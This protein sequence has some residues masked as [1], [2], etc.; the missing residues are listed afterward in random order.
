MNWGTYLF[1]VIRQRSGGPSDLLSGDDG[2]GKAVSQMLVSTSIHDRPS[3]IL[4]TPKSVFRT[5]TLRGESAGLIRLGNGELTDSYRASDRTIEED[6]HE[7]LTGKLR[8]AKRVFRRVGRR[9]EKV[10]GGECLKG[11]YELNSTRETSPR[12]SIRDSLA[13]HRVLTDS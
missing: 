6:P 1:V 2:A 8:C 3:E 7:C 9:C 10:L 11:L 5:G 4:R 12:L 13:M